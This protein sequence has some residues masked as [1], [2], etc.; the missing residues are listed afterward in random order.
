MYRLT[1]RLLFLVPPER[2]HTL[3]FALLRGVTTVALAPVGH[4]HSSG[5]SGRRP[6]EPALSRRDFLR[7][8]RTRLL[9]SV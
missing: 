4:R 9:P 5:W 6:V 2:I 8:S 3:V 7:R 1:R